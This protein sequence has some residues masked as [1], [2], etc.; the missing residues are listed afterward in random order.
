MKLKH[1][2][3]AFLLIAV[4]STSFACKKKN[5][6]TSSLETS[7]VVSSS[8]YS[9]S[10]P[11][12]S[13]DVSSSSL[14]SPVSYPDYY[15]GYYDSLTTWENGADL[16][17]KLNT[18]IRTGYTALPYSSPNWES[19]QYADQAISDFESV[20][21]VY[22]AE[23]ELKS[24]TN[25]N[26]VGWQREHAFC[27]SL[28]TGKTTGD[29][30]AT[31]GRATDFHNLFA[32]NYSGNTSR[33]NKNYGQ[34]NKDSS[35]Y[36][37][38]TSNNGKD[39]YSFD[40]MTFEPGDYDKGRLA[41]A[42][43]Y[44]GTMYMDPEGEYKGLSIVEGNI[45]Y[46]AGLSCQY[47]IG[48]LSTLIKWN[49]LPVDRLEYQHNISV[50]SH[51]FNGVA[52]GNRNPFVDYPELVDYVYGWKKNSAGKLSDLVPSAHYLKV[53]SK[54]HSNYAIESAKRA[55]QLDDVIT[56]DD[57]VVVDV[58]K[59]Y[60]YAPVKLESL[61]DSYTF[62]EADVMA[63]TKMITIETPDGPL[64]YRVAVESNDVSS[65]KY[66]YTFENKNMFGTTGAKI[67]ATGSTVDLGGL[68][69]TFSYS[70]SVND[71]SI[72][73]SNN[74]LGIAIGTGSS[75]NWAETLV[76]TCEALM[77]DISAVY[78]KANTAS[79]VNYRMEITAGEKST[80]SPINISRNA[81]ASQIY[82]QKFEPS[83][84]K[85]TIRIKNVTKA[86]YLQQIAVNY[87][88]LL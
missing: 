18:I 8:V 79:G 14:L 51:E 84:G 49:E 86:F 76:I 78:I 16:K 54:E 67:L 26:G 46:S 57:C 42:I 35:T 45:A 59:D 20:D 22:S 4:F 24:A 87:G 81:E 74:T 80:L 40:S 47:A 53:N 60:S 68:K 32:S 15:D 5:K 56:I 31:L 7:S 33:G 52:Q 55:Y 27:A 10:I 39:G 50:Y 83:N 44:M 63:K 64:R 70:S 19:N 71:V 29:A 43:F 11:L 77:S 30:V 85:V 88:D 37:N 61:T 75:N 62:T 2:L 65:C 38:K 6:P 1:A 17:R 28:M 48:N 9:S 25:K 12:S 13:S 34:A 3:T 41:R 69:W 72:P 21:V 36:Q 58:A 82:G 66:S 23:N 73:V